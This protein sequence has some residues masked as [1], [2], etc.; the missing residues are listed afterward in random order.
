MSAEAPEVNE[1]NVEPTTAA[2]A[3][4]KHSDPAATETND[5]A[6]TEGSKEDKPATEADAGGE[7]EVKLYV[8]NLPDNCR[9]AS[10]EELFAKYGKV[11]QCDRVKNFAFVVSFEYKFTV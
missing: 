8:G 11:T 1:N 4:E 10:L 5:Q 6:E 9:R 2:E 7:K 3:D